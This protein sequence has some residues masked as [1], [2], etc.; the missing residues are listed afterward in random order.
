M[1]K[2]SSGLILAEEA[3][4][5]PDAIEGT[6]VSSEVVPSAFDR[7]P[8]ALRDNVEKA[9]E[10][11]SLPP[12][13][14]L[15]K[16][17]EHLG[18]DADPEAGAQALLAWCRDEYARRKTGQPVAHVADNGKKRQNAPITNGIQAK[19]PDNFYRADGKD[20]QPS[21]TVAPVEVAAPVTT[22]AGPVGTVGSSAADTAPSASGF[23][24]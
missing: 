20:V 23:D 8:E 2:L 14:R 18:G 1:A 19:A 17:N 13:M 12:A 21:A 7:V 3:M 16:L 10:T 11:L 22:A 15:V 4:D 6:V 5:Y 24:F 9:F